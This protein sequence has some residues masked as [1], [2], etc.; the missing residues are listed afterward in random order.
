VKPIVLATD[1]SPSAEEATKI[2][3][4][5]AREKEARLFV[6]AAWGA[7]LT[8]HRY[9]SDN[10]V[11]EVE[12]AERGRAT[13]AARAVLDLAREAGVEAESVVARDMPSTSSRRRRQPSEGAGR[14]SKLASRTLAQRTACVAHVSACRVA[15]S[16]GV[17]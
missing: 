8:I 5:L 10:T 9:A 1:G 11:P 12:K 17:S 4:E 13:A 7:P 6:V 3:I 14:D 15:S 2:A 16:N